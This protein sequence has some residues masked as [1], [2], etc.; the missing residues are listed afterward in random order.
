MSPMSA[1]SNTALDHLGLVLS[2]LAELSPHDRCEGLDDAQAFYNAARPEA[3][4]APTAGYVT[5][6]VHVGPLDWPIIDASLGD[7][8]TNAE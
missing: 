2:L 6:L 3:I 8:V 7:G 1:E 4:I 5:R